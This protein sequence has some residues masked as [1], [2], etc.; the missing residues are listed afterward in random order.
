MP[1]VSSHLASAGAGPERY[2]RGEPPGKGKREIQIPP[3]GGTFW[4]QVFI[5]APSPELWRK[6]ISVG[7]SWR[8]GSGVACFGLPPWKKYRR[9]DRDV[10]PRWMD[11]TVYRAEVCYPFGREHGRHRAVRRREFITLLGGVAM[12]P[13]AGRAQQSATSIPRVGWLVTGSPAEYRFS[14]AAFRGG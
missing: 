13:L 10:P 4:F 5:Q 11:A 2:R 12:W 14:L 8:H 7:G 9:R 3:V 1:P 6:M